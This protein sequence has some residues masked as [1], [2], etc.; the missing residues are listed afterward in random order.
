MKAMMGKVNNAA[1]MFK[2]VLGVMWKNARYAA[3]C[4]KAAILYTLTWEQWRH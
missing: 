4:I 1:S 3:W 2:N